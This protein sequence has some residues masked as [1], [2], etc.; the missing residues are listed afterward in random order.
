M[1]L[2]QAS[3]LTKQVVFLTITFLVVGIFSF[4]GYQVW[5]VYYLSTI[6]PIEEIADSKFGLLPYPSFPPSNV[7]SSNFSYTLDTT[8]GNTPTLGQDENFPRLIKVY[9]ISQPYTSLLSS[10]RIKKIATDLEVST[11][12]TVSSDVEYT[13][14]DETKNLKINLDSGNF[15]FTNEASVAALEKLDDDQ[16]L[17]T[18][19]QRLLTKLNFFKEELL[20]GRK[21]VTLLKE[22][23][24]D[25]V[26][27][28]SRS[29]AKGA[30]I[31][32]WRTNLGSFP[33]VTPKFS[34]AL[35]NATVMYSTN[36]LENYRSINYVNWSI[37][38]EEFGTYELKDPTVAFEELKSGKATIIIE[39]PK[40]QVSINNIRIA[41]YMPDKYSLYLLPI[42][43][44]EG[45][46]FVAYL[47][48]IN[49][50]D[51]QSTP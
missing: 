50:Q 37:D 21:E 29:E 40:P 16:Q 45:P 32:F 8:T 24:F 49:E 46:Q 47:S 7:T 44:F 4:I 27:T 19:F 3:I 6:P 23:G 39:P 20:D 41:Y 33:I 51:H 1:T 26:P 38:Q 34:Q 48:A 28:Q 12:P 31:S 14:E 9:F 17:I 11:E 13:F 35:I 10:E 30:L 36:S 2:T 25:L 18:G 15:N 22:D 5:R 42:Y 43:V